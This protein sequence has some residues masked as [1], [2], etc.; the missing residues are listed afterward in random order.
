MTL[1]GRWFQKSFIYEGWL[2]TN[3]YMLVERGPKQVARP[4][5]NYMNTNF[6]IF[7]IVYFCQRETSFFSFRL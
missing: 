7:K 1:G 2:K 4:G 5:K 6:L 3:E